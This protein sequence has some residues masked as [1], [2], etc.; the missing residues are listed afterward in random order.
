MLYIDKALV[1]IKT[2]HFVCIVDFLYK[3]L[4]LFTLLCYQFS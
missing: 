3:K 2:H 1:R 4:S